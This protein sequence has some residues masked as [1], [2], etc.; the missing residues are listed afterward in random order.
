MQGSRFLV[1]VDIDICSVEPHTHPSDCGPRGRA[2]VLEDRVIS[3]IVRFSAKR[4]AVNVAVVRSRDLPGDEVMR[5]GG[6]VGLGGC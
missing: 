4:L 3:D 5:S 2:K 6:L 1:W